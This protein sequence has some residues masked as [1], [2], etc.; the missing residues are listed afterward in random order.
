MEHTEYL[1]GQLLLQ[2]VL[3]IDLKAEDMVGPFL[4]AEVP[5]VRHTYGQAMGRGGEE[6]H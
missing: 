5:V 2:D 1:V 6:R 3:N 4:D